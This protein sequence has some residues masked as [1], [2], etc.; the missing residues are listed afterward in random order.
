MSVITF[1]FFIFIRDP[2]LDDNPRARVADMVYGKAHKPFVYR[3]LL[4]GIV[5]IGV[6]II[7]ESVKSA[8]NEQFGHRI[9]LGLGWPVKYTTEYLVAS[10]CMWLS[11]ILFFVAIRYLCTGIYKVSDNVA[12]LVALTTI[13]GLP[14]FF[15]YA[16]YIYDFPVLFLFTVG[17]GL[18][19]RS[20]WVP[21]AILF[22]FACV[23]KETAIL[24]TM[25]FTIHFFHAT[26]GMSR[27]LFHKLLLYQICVFVLIKF[28]LFYIFMAN[29]GSFVE[30]HLFDHNMRMLF[31]PY[32]LGT[33][34]NWGIVMA[35]V[36]Y[37]WSEKPS[38]LKSGLWICVPL[39]L[40]TL[41][42]GFLD[43]LRDFYEVYPIVLLL[44]FHGINS[45]LGLKLINSE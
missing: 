42:F 10:V 23:N 3:V 7:P 18:M 35:L 4:P 30:F 21:F 20:K 13:A 45:L 19:V 16:S 29:P 24:L 38:F 34:L 36:F 15:S 22:P 31:H 37:G 33:F 25:I 6:S 12:N 40:L 41:L 2:G 26:H 1:V 14:I 17:L 5:R 8:I 32:P 11:L 43:E 39:F 28:A 9:P 27:T 44:S